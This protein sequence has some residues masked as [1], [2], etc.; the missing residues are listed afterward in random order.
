MT[1]CR[2]GDDKTTRRQDDATATSGVHDTLSRKYNIEDI[3][4]ATR[5]EDTR[6]EQTQ[7][8]HENN[9]DDGDDDDDD[10][11]D[12]EFASVKVAITKTAS[13]TSTCMHDDCS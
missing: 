8:P 4:A 13:L 6:Q 2:N 7:Q 5:R 11:D 1:T 9:N 3:D 12:D 10:D